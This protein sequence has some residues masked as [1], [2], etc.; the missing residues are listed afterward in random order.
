MIEMIQS[1]FRHQQWADTALLQAVHGSVETE[2]DPQ[3]RGTLHHIVNVQR[4]FLALFLRRPFA[5]REELTVPES[6]ATVEQHF[7]EAHCEE[8]SFVSS[9][10]ESDLA[11]VIEMPWIPGSRPSLAQALMQVVMHSSNHRG[12]CLSRL[13][14]LGV[15]PPTLD[16]IVWLK[17]HP[18]E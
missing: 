2:N 12:Q 18:A 4:A 10:R 17:D 8:M 6:L 14:T 3:L 16:F 9:L 5:M 15:T 13:R 7:R 11:R 1:L